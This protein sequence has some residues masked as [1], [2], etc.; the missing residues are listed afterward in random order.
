[1]SIVQHVQDGRRA[2]ES[3]MTSRVQI[4]KIEKVRDPN[5]GSYI[6]T[7]VAV[8]T[9]KARIHTRSVAATRDDVLGQIITQQDLVLSIPVPGTEVVKPDMT[10]KV[11]A[12]PLD[13]TLVGV[14]FILKGTSGESQ[15]VARRFTIERNS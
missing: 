11:T 13:E 12:N 15:Q 4:G 9:G 5:T 2:A 8:W 3:I 7:F 10:V 1:M 6:E 14:T